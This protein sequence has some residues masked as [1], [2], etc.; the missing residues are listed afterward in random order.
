MSLQ[1][2][3]S[4]FCEFEECISL[5]GTMNVG[6]KIT[7]QQYKQ[8]SEKPKTK[9]GKKTSRYPSKRKHQQHSPKWLFHEHYL[10]NGPCRGCSAPF[11]CEST[12]SYTE[13]PTYPRKHERRA[14]WDQWNSDRIGGY[15]SILPMMSIQGDL[16]SCLRFGRFGAVVW[17]SMTE[18]QETRLQCCDTGKTHALLVDPNKP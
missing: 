7:I 9:T 18:Y 4:G 2:K 8:E 1:I 15:W 3:L 11:P 17:V 16:D 12:K 5:G 13:E 14:T 10:R 6:K